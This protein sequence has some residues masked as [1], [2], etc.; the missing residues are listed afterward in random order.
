V[1]VPAE[2]ATTSRWLGR[3]YLFQIGSYRASSYAVMLYFGCVLG[4]LAGAA[5]AKAAG[6]DDTRF[7]L[8]AVVLVI[9]ALVGGRLWFLLERPRRRRVDPKLFWSTQEGGAGLYGGLVLSFAVSPPLL[10]ATGLD[11]WRFWDAAAVVLLI[12]MIVTRFGC[13]MNG[14]CAGRAAGRPLG[15]W[16][17]NYAGEWQRRYPTQLFEAGWSGL[18][19]AAEMAMRPY[20]RFPGAL[21]LSAAAAYAAGRLVLEPLREVEGG[22]SRSTHLNL[23]FSAVLLIVASVGLA[24]PR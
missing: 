21:F 10:V 19:L 23:A 16:L 7:A 11:F 2:P 9:P 8:T 3:R 13:L 4:V 22:G 17:P 18:V 12:G 24:W 20:L 6:L 15:M 5:V 14:C 1:S